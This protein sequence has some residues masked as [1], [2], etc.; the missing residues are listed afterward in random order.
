MNDQP[1]STASLAVWVLVFIGIGS[2]ILA[3]L[4]PEHAGRFII[5]GA[6]S[7]SIAAVFLFRLL[8]RK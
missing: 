7:Y 2:L 4:P 6:V 1:D 3:N 8:V 5:A